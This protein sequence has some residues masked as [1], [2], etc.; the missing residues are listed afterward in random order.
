MSN[1]NLIS[2]NAE[3]IDE[4]CEMNQ[5]ESI[6]M[7]NDNYF[8]SEE[9]IMESQQEE[10]L[11][12]FKLINLVKRAEKNPKIK[13][14][15]IDMIKKIYPEE[16]LNRITHLLENLNDDN[17]VK[18]LNGILQLPTKIKFSINKNLG[19]EMPPTLKE[20]IDIIEGMFIAIKKSGIKELKD[21]FDNRG[22]ILD[23]LKEN[24]PSFLLVGPPGCGKTKFGIAI[25][26]IFG[27][28]YELIPCSSTDYLAL[29]G[30]SQHWGNATYGR[31]AE[32]LIRANTFPIVYIF[33]E[34]DKTGNSNDY[35]TIDAINHI[36]DPIKPFQDSFLGVSLYHLLICPIILTAND[37][38]LIPDYVISRCKVIEVNKL[39]PKLLINIAYSNFTKNFKQLIQIY[40]KDIDEFKNSAKLRK[41]LSRL[42]AIKNF[43]IRAVKKELKY[44]FWKFL[45]FYENNRKNSNKDMFDSLL[46]LIEKEIEKMRKQSKKTYGKKIGFV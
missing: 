16:Y 25:A 26:E 20:I 35:K 1:K 2:D 31:I 28:P 12:K 5:E 4:V 38:S 8:I 34:I 33:D 11:D 37:I 23:W 22:E 41:I 36:I 40:T 6:E 18:I 7:S 14:M 9:E 27:L 17:N 45:K 39:D 46:E 19:Y 30:L 21:F 32:G 24:S 29:S 10:A 44:I 3:F 13:L 42:V 15:L 43:D